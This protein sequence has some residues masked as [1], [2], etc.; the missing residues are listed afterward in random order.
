[1]KSLTLIKLV[2]A[3]LIYHEEQRTEIEASII[4]F[5]T[6]GITLEYRHLLSQSEMLGGDGG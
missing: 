3:R 1:M 6:L 5:L 4:N 2:L